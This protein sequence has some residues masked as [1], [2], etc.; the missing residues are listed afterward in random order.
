MK[1]ILIVL[2][3]LINV[4]AESFFS[5]KK[6]E[7]GSSY[8]LSLKDLIV[9]TQKTRGLTNSYLNGNSD[10]LATIKKHQNEMK[11]AI[12]QLEAS[13]MVSDPTIEFYTVTIS[14]E[15]TLLNETAIKMDPAKAFTNYTDQ[16][17]TLIEWAKIVSYRSKITRNSLGQ[18]ITDLLTK[19]LLPMIEDIAQVRGIGSGVIAKGKIDKEEIGKILALSADVNTLR[20]KMEEK[21]QEILTEY[22]TVYNDD[23]Y[24]AVDF[25]SKKIEK[26]MNSTANMLISSPNNVDSDQ[27]FKDGTAIINMLL[28]LQKINYRASQH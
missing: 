18:E 21:M 6:Q 17:S 11:E 20:E 25:I 3:L 22:S 24:K 12:G 13:P 14:K 7:N 23:T 28:K 4:N 26:Y 1:V 10:V 5:N 19:V 2:L 16:I 9:A 15:L 8:I 27:Y